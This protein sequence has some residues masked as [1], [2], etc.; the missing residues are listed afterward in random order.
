M[1][2]L[3]SVF[4]S[5]KLSGFL[6]L[7]FLFLLFLYSKHYLD[8]H[9]K[10]ESSGPVS[11]RTSIFHPPQMLMD[12]ATDGC[13]GLHKYSGEESKCLYV[14]THPSCKP[15]GYINYVQFFYCNIGHSHLLGY[16]LCLLWLLILFYLLGNTAST[17]FCSSLENLSKVL[18]LSP[19]IA[20]ITLLSLGNGANDV[21]AS[22]ISFTKSGSGDVGLNSILGGAF[23]VSSVVI[24]IISILINPKHTAI[25]KSGFVRDVLFFLFSLS[26]LLIIII[27]G[28]VNLWSAICF[29]SIYFVYVFVVS[30]TQFFCR[31]KI[32]EE[33]EK[34]PFASALLS[35][36]SK[37]LDFED[38]A[39]A[40]IGIP[41][42]AYADNHV[43]PGLQ[44]QKS[45]R[46][47]FNFDLMMSS[48]SL[49]KFL[50]ILELPLY[51]PRRLTIPVVS[52]DRWSKPYAVVSV[53]FAPILLAALLNTQTDNVD[54]ETCLITYM[55]A[56]LI[57]ILLGNMAYVSTKRT[58]P[59]LKCLLPWLAGGFVM[60]VTWTYIIAEELVSLLIS[61]GYIVGVNPSI[62]GLTVLAWG[63]SL[64]DLISNA[65][66]AM[67]SGA[68]GVHIAVAGCYAGPMFNTLVGIGLPL[69]MSSWS[70]YPK[71]YV[72]PRDSSLYETLGF[73]MAG[74]LWALVM[75]PNR[76]MKLDR[77][78]GFGLL[79]IYMCFLFLKA[80]TT[81]G[82]VNTQI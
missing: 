4:R 35:P 58:T 66:M 21:F 72:I 56:S 15:K 8:D 67:N 62:L 36:S 76:K 71:S 9:I 11:S 17:Y 14:K 78:L 53:T 39:A 32:E 7:S 20:G 33:E 27:T 69:V 24:G 3:A 26:T 41:L 28:K 38:A 48:A 50:F 5:K 60:S 51:L 12:V 19:T 34:N 37:I 57:G 63:N 2:N 22:I 55:T 61:V 52:E 29:V 49:S 68:D 80:A 47:H 44:V 54:S 79:A 82:L 64:G 40:G 59:P 31:N 77:F 74:L 1:A 70:D 42:L 65:S 10:S 16:I 13:T 81:F 6:N 30:V 25:D 45:S 43:K 46:V 18:K 23:F 75:L 73:L